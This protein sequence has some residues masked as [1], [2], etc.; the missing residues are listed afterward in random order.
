MR[1]LDSGPQQNKGNMFSFLTLSTF[2]ITAPKINNYLATEQLWQM[3]NWSQ[4]ASSHDAINQYVI[5]QKGE[6]S[7][8][9][10]LQNM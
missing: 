9:Y 2:T 8:L 1:Y 10:L 4:G 6:V 3:I 5:K 7:N